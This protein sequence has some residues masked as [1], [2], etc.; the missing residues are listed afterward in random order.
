M[1]RWNL[2]SGL[3]LASAFLCLP[4]LSSAAPLTLASAIEATLNANPQLAGY[5]YRYQSLEGERHTAGLGAARELSV[6]LEDLHR[7]NQY[8]QRKR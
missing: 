5:Q 1:V 4:A 8:Q 6:E 2:F 3:C 7:C